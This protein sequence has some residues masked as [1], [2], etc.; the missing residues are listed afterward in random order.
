MGSRVVAD[1]NIL[2]DVLT[3]RQPALDEMLRHSSLAISVVTW[4]EVLAGFRHSEA[5]L[6]QAVE[7]TFEVIPLSAAIAE[8]AVLLRQT[9]HLKLP[10]AVILATAHVD[11]SLLLTRNTRDFKEGRYVRIP[12]R[13]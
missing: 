7:D 8:E 6:R 10:D 5:R 3:G 11:Q 4:I 13:F 12:Y 9:T 1:S 2:I